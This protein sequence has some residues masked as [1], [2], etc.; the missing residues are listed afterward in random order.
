MD[1][2][3]QRRQQTQNKLTDL[4]NTLAS[5]TQQRDDMQ[6]QLNDLNNIIADCQVG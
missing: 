6:R 5:T 4:N 3:T 2:L 1:T